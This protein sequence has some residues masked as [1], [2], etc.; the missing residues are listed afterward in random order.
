M[1]A[2]ASHN[3]C[4]RLPCYLTVGVLATGAH[5]LTL[6]LLSL[7]LPALIATLL[8]GLIGTA[9]SYQGNKR[10]TFTPPRPPDTYQW[11]RF[12]ITALAYNAANLGLMAL[13]LALWP[14][15]LWLMQGLTTLALTLL[16]YRINQ[17]WS[18]RHE[19]IKT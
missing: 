19:P 11:L 15:H 8:G 14:Q 9:V 10:W 13:L 7:A 17:H 6:L 3:T 12:C 16:T 2:P 18:F 5:Y 1:T 4:A